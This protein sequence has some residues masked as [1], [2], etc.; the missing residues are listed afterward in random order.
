MFAASRCSYWL[1]PVADGGVV[2]PP[3]ARS[4]ASRTAP[5]ATATTGIT[6]QAIRRQLQERETLEVTGCPVARSISFDS[7]RLHLAALRVAGRT[8][9]EAGGDEAGRERP[10]KVATA[11]IDGK[12][13][14]RVRWE[15]RRA[16]CARRCE[17]REGGAEG[18]VVGV[19]AVANRR[20]SGDGL[21][22]NVDDIVR[23]SSTVQVANRLAQVDGKDVR[24]EQSCQGGSRRAGQRIQGRRHFVGVDTLVTVRG[25]AVE[26][27]LLIFG[28]E[29]SVDGGTR[30]AVQLYP[31]PKVVHLGGS[32][33]E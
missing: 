6:C 8:E 30:H 21:E 14:A 20:V 9:Q 27:I 23:E 7:L 19:H 18:L 4:R 3:P 24:Q 29:D 12:P 11:F 32:R 25:V 2:P 13:A 22:R 5:R 26:R 10:R 1:S 16:T 28:D 33:P 15:R 31:L 17:I